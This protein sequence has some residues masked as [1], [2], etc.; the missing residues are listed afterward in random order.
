MTLITIIGHLGRD[1]E[2]RTTR[3]RTYTARYYDSVAEQW[4]ESEV[5]PPTREYALLS[6]AADERKSGRRETKWH[7]VICWNTE[8]TR[9]TGVQLARRGDKVQITGYQETFRWKDAEG[10]MREIKQLI[11]DSFELLQPK[12]RC[13][14]P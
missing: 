4:T 2:I 8:R 11:L 5:T 12:V 1:R 10:Q 14:V 6:L 9:A 3:Q 13:Q 7:R